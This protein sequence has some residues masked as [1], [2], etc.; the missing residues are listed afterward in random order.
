MTE[1]GKSETHNPHT[2]TVTPTQVPHLHVGPENTKPNED[3]FD[4][5]IAGFLP[6]GGQQR[7]SWDRGCPKG[8]Q[9]PREQRLH[10]HLWQAPEGDTSDV[11]G[12]AGVPNHR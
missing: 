10:G 9:K 5:D 4:L 8:R 12:V 7:F 3:H 2:P 11:H 1:H 6:D